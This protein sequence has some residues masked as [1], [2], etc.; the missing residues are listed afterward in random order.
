MALRNF[1]FIGAQAGELFQPGNIVRMGVPPLRLE[2]MTAISGVDFEDCY[3][4]R[5]EENWDGVLV[6]ILSREDLIRNK[7]ATGRLKDRAD[8]E[9]L[10]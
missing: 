4:R 2:I 1:G 6:P 9:E 5:V 3:T 8:V 7:K 10:S